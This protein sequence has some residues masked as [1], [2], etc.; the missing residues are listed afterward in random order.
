MGYAAG[1]A[2]ATASILGACTTPP[3]TDPPASPSTQGLPT[4]S[5]TSGTAAP[6][7]T[8]T[9]SSS[10]T[11]GGQSQ[12]PEVAK[13]NTPQGA[14]AFT[15]YFLSEAN[16]AYQTFEAARITALVSPDCA[17]CKNMTDSIS[18]WKGKQYRYT[19]EYASPTYI[20]ISSFTND[21]TA[22]VLVSSRTSE[23]KLLDSNNSVVETFPADN[24]NVSVFLKYEPGSW[25]VSEIKVAT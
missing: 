9:G 4:S 18:T 13:A 19:G 10:T 25:V 8:A 23:S 11:G 22:K 24:S 16:R 21:N 7:T 2:L 20:A 15:R 17:A 6:K 12:L 14:E 1:L 5:T 3:A